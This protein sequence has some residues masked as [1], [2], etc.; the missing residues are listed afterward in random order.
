MLPLQ[1]VCA[2]HAEAVQHKETGTAAFR[3][4]DLQQAA[5]SY[6]GMAHRMKPASS[7]V[8]RHLDSFADCLNMVDETTTSG[9][10]LASDAYCNRALL[11]MRQQP[12]DNQ[13]ALQD[14]SCA[15][16]CN[17]ANCKASNG[18]VIHS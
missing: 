2:D 9:S 11:L 16:A 4:R 13:G 15:I 17:G 1:G 18:H 10:A 12:P 8:R 7:S 3:K 14:S 5:V 6:S